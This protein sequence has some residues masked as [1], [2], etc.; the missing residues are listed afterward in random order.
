MAFFD[1]FYVFHCTLW[2]LHKKANISR[3]GL[4]LA[5][6]PAASVAAL[7]PIKNNQISATV[8]LLLPVFW[9]HLHSMFGCINWWQNSFVIRLVKENGPKTLLPDCIEIVSAQL[10]YASFFG[11][12]SCIVLE[13]LRI[14]FH[15]KSRISFCNWFSLAASMPL[16]IGIHLLAHLV[17]LHSNYWQ[18]DVRNYLPGVVSL[19][20]QLIP[21]CCLLIN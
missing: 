5:A 3:L 15:F 21:L 19:M 9:I 12:P 16:H 10:L 17:F 18:I 11:F 14:A 4:C 6:R 1:C 7:W 20:G 13:F 8:N 2:V